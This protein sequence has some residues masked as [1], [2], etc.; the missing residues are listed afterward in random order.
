MAVIRSFSPVGGPEDIAVAVVSNEDP[1]DSPRIE[2]LI[3]VIGLVANDEQM[4]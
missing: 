2:R 3:P 4:P 1:Y